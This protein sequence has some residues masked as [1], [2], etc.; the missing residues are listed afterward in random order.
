MPRPRIEIQPAALLMF[1]L[2]FFF[3]ADGL[4]SAL[5]PA[6]CVHELGHLLALKACGRRILCLRVAITGLELD[7]APRLEGLQSILCA[8][9][10][11]L[12]GGIYA[13]AACAAGRPFWLV[14]GAAS[15][16]LTAFNLLP[17]LPLDGG[18][19]LSALLPGKAG[20][21]LS[22]A[23]A[24]LLL[25]GGVWM[26]LSFQSPAL[27]FAGAWLTLCNATCFFRASGIE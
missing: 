23:A 13:L 24:A 4:L 26:F 14:S 2:A 12:A 7:Y 22:F 1:A 19:V 5:V 25:S 11:P 9:A 16:L 15:F 27:L 17:I 6:V 18:R 3:D 8:A 20:R 21:R 10:G